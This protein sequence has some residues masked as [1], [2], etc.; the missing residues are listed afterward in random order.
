MPCLE[1]KP[2]RRDRPAYSPN[3]IYRVLQALSSV[4]DEEMK[5]AGSED[6]GMDAPRS[7][8]PAP[9]LAFR[10][11]GSQIWR[12]VTVTAI[13]TGDRPMLAAGLPALRN[14]RGLL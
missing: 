11:L 6:P 9:L 8:E 1:R 13:H 4:C 5:V 10:T 7:N 3:P 12:R 2:E 14:Q